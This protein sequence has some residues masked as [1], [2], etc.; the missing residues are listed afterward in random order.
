VGALRLF[1]DT[2]GLTLWQIQTSDGQLE[3]R[4]R[5]SE[6]GSL[7]LMADLPMESLFRIPSLLL[8][9]GSP[10]LFRGVAEYSTFV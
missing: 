5:E 1:L 6:E 3:E 10:F 7:R 2:D 8:A 4:A 9:G